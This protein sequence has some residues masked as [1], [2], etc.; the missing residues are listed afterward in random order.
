MTDP[1]AWRLHLPTGRVSSSDRERGHELGRSSWHP[2]SSDP[3]DSPQLATTVEAIRRPATSGCTF[4][5]H[6]TPYQESSWAWRTVRR[7]ER[8]WRKATHRLRNQGRRGGLTRPLYLRSIGARG[9]G[10]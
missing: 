4:I 10:V 1:A 6:L 5:D 8:P 7:V 3:R 2:S 9:A